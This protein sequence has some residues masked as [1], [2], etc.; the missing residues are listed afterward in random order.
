MGQAGSA[1]CGWDVCLGLTEMCSHNR[2]LRRGGAR[3]EKGA[4]GWTFWGSLILTVSGL[5][6]KKS[7]LSEA[8]VVASKERL[9][10]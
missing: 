10:N 6:Q 1:G 4:G 7:N 9:N 2:A 5:F 3:R 8:D